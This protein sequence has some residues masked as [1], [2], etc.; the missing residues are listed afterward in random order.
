MGYF[1]VLLFLALFALTL[2]A[3]VLNALHD[4]RKK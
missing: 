4:L 2:V 1:C 3:M